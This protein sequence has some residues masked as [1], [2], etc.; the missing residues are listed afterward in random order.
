M[1]CSRYRCAYSW[2]LFCLALG[3]CMSILI[4][5]CGTYFRSFQT[6][7]TFLF[8]MYFMDKIC[9][10]VHIKE[11]EHLSTAC[12]CTGCDFLRTSLQKLFI[13]LI[14]K[15][16]YP[17]SS[18]ASYSLCLLSTLLAQRLKIN[19]LTFIIFF[20]PVR[21]LVLVWPSFS[22]LAELIKLLRVIYLFDRLLSKRLVKLA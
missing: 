18:N 3:S 10:N 8:S 5:L 14:N 6:M 2:L 19:F 22:F 1:C 15:L 4:Q 20:F 9:W 17:I 12:F 21:C 13:E 11:Y 7:K 16:F